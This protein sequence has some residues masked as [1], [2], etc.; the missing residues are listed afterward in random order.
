[1]KERMEFQMK[2]EKRNGRV[3]G[4]SI[5]LLIVICI[6]LSVV[7]IQ[8]SATVDKDEK[9]AGNFRYM[10]VGLDGYVESTAVVVVLNGKGA[11]AYTFANDKL[12]DEK[13]GSLI[14]ALSDDLFDMK[15]LETINVNGKTLCSWQVDKITSDS[16]GVLSA[17]M[18]TA[19]GKYIAYYMCYE[20]DELFYAYDLIVGLELAKDFE[21]G[22]AVLRLGSS[23]SEADSFKAGMLMN[24]EAECVGILMGN[25][26]AYCEWFDADVFENGSDSVTESE[27][28][29]KQIAE[30]F[31]NDVDAI[32]NGQ[33]DSPITP[34]G[35]GKM[36][37]GS[38][39]SE[40][41]S[42]IYSVTVQESGTYLFEM[43]PLYKTE[44]NKLFSLVLEEDDSGEINVLGVLQNSSEYN[45]ETEQ[46]LELKIS[47]P[48]TYYLSIVFNTEEDTDS[49]V[50]YKV[51]VTKN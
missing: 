18:P 48:G 38:I 1:M 30:D 7:P 13:E 36:I 8:A 17:G 28:Q 29:L 23:L 3:L 12:K 33:D 5:V 34:L 31:V 25:D 49:T 50:F 40:D 32:E 11:Y 39:S 47:R 37:A 46:V 24:E 22:T 27:A 14:N 2:R 6:A 16:P 19:K 15:G 35:L 51:R 20:N 26:R 21:D 43:I 9:G 44:I 10:A 45:Y 41:D 42:D 4:K